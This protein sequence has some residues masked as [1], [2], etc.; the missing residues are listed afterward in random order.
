MA[1]KEGFEPPVP[2]PAQLISSQSHS[3]TLALLHP[4]DSGANWAAFKNQQYSGLS[5]WPLWATVSVADQGSITPKIPEG[6]SLLWIAGSTNECN[7]LEIIHLNLAQY[8]IYWHFLW[9]SGAVA[10]W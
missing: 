3:A 9:S 4:E 8:F 7:D 10:K 2:F 5:S 6:Q 1:E